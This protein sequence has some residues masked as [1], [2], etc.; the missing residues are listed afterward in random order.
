MGVGEMSDHV[1]D[2]IAELKAWAEQQPRRPVK[3]YMPMR[4][5]EV[6]RCAKELA[7]LWG[8]YDLASQLLEFQEEIEHEAT[9]TIRQPVADV[10]ATEGK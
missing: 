2:H 9:Q 8:Y 7:V 4:A 3:G 1:A 6:I 5:F 10:L